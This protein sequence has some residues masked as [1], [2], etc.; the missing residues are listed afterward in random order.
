MGRG[1]GRAATHRLLLLLL[2]GSAAPSELAEAPGASGED[3]V[4]ADKTPH[5]LNAGI[6]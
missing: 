6:H 5:H 2:L 1:L 4:F 3:E